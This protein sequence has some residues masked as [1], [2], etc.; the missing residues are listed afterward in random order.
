MVALTIHR[1]DLDMVFFF[2]H[3]DTGD[4]FIAIGDNLQITTM[5]EIFSVAHTTITSLFGQP[6]TYFWVCSLDVEIVDLL[7]RK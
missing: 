5:R 3:G 1:R 4:M 7:R 6:F 2:W